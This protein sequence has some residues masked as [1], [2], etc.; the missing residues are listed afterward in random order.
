MALQILDDIQIAQKLRR[1]AFE[2]YENNYDEQH[3]VFAGI[4]DKGYEVASLIAHHLH[5]I[6]PLNSQLVRV[7]LDKANPVGTP[8]QLDTDLKNLEGKCIVLVDD[9][10]NTGRTLV[11]GM[12]PFLSIAI[13]KMEIAVLVNR[14]HTHFPVYATYSGYELSTSLT[15]HIDVVLEKD[16]NAVY[17]N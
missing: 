11:Y 5:Q 1:I 16:K 12:K 7:S 2:I 8:V 15:E 6:S 9:V 4:D 3:I 17:L 10:L 13:K 14:S